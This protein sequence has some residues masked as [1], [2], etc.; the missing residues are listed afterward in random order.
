MSINLKK[1]LEVILGIDLE[2]DIVL[3]RHLTTTR[4]QCVGQQAMAYNPKVMASVPSE[5]YRD[6]PNPYCNNC[7]GTGWVF[8]ESISKCKYFYT[9]AMVA[10]NQD[11]YYGGTFSNIM[12]IYLPITDK[13]AELNVNDLVYQLKAYKDGRLYNP[14]IRTRKWIITDKYD[15]HLDNNKLEFFKLYT[16]PAVV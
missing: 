7:E 15:M 2:H 8:T 1:E 10:H 4:C 5:A 9:P 13:T 16:K 6:V 11:Y 12:T 14:L 3:L